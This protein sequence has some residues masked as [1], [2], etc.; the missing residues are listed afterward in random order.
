M[1]KSI[2]ALTLAAVGA[3]GTLVMAQSHD[4]GTQATTAQS[5]SADDAN[6][7]QA[8]MTALD[9]ADASLATAMTSNDP[10]KTRTALEDAKKQIAEAKRQLSMCPMMKGGMMGHGQMNHMSH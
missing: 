1:N 6:M 8:A 2:L 7:M 4:H 5:S 10:A 9:K 3:F